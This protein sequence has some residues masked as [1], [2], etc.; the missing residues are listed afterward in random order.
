MALRISFARTAAVLLAL[1]AMALAMILPDGAV[2]AKATTSVD[3]G[4][5]KISGKAFRFGKRYP[6]LVNALI[7]VREYPDLYTLSDQNG[8]YELE[9]PDNANVTPY[10]VSGWNGAYED[11]RTNPLDPLTKHYNSVDLQTFHTRGQDIVNANFQTPTDAEYN[12]LKALLKVKSDANNRPEQCV[13]VTTSS[14]RNVRDVD[15]DTYWDRTPHGVA[16]ATAYTL[17]DMLKPSYFND[18]VLPDPN[19][20]SSSHDGGIIWAVVPT[21]TYRVITEHPDTRFASFLATCEPGRVVNANP[22]W[23]AYELAPGEAPLPASNVAAKVISAKAARK[24]RKNRTVSVTVEAGEQIDATATLVKGGKTLGTKQVSLS[25]GNPAIKFAVKPN[26]KPGKA[27]VNVS[28]A[29]ASKVS[30]ASTHTVKLPKVLKKKAKKKSRAKQRAK[31]KA[32]Q[33]AKQKAKAKARAKN[34]R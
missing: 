20:L 31:A 30:F 11:P 19:Q 23:G 2:A 21:G 3:G 1:A 29:D 22:P 8:D 33:K 5:V 26:V 6:I 32:K 27:T 16:G 24:G 18:A 34:R 9:V 4:T 15:Y 12:A 25:A 7:R 14:A 13:I 17:P 10:I 28:L